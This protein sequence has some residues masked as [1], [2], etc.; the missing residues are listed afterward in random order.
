MTFGFHSPTW[1]STRA[2]SRRS[3]RCDE[4]ATHDH[5]CAPGDSARCRPRNPVPP[6]TS[7][8]RARRGRHQLD[9]RTATAGAYAPPADHGRR[10]PPGPAPVAW[11]T[12]PAPQQVAVERHPPLAEPCPPGWVRVDLHSHTMWSGDSTTTPDEV[13]A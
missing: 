2:R 10:G 9:C 4:G 3:S 12:V 11:H 7:I 1:S 6:V 8:E 5:A 13:E